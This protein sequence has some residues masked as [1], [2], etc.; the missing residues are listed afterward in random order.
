MRDV[1]DPVSLSSGWSRAVC[2]RL[3]RD[4]QLLPLHRVHLE[5][6]G[7]MRAIETSRS[8]F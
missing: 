3:R 1:R 6:A 7:A 2:R 8:A 5:F 4:A